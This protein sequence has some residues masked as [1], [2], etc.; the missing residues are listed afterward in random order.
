ML[1]FMLYGRETYQPVSTHKGIDNISGSR[2]QLL[3]DK[4][5]RQDSKI[6][7]TNLRRHTG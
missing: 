3:I 4:T 1:F 7:Q 2:H 5:V 6:R